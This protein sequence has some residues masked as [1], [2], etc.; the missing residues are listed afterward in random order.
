LRSPLTHLLS[1]KGIKNLSF[2]KGIEHCELLIRVPMKLIDFP[3][4]CFDITKFVIRK[5]H[6]VGGILRPDAEDSLAG[7]NEQNSENNET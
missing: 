7:T 2:E 3:D 1:L 5:L 4:N 6:W